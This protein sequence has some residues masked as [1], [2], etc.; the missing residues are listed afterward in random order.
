MSLKWKNELKKKQS[1]LILMT[2]ITVLFSVVVLLIDRA[3]IGPCDTS[4]GLS[5]LN[6]WVRDLIG[7][8][9]LWYVISKLS[10]YLCLILCAGFG[11]IGLAQLIHHKSLKKMDQ[12]I[13]AL[14]L[15]YVCTI[16]LYVFFEKVPLNFRPLLMEG[17][18]MPEA[19]FPSSHTMLAI[20][21]Y[22]SAPTVL[23][24]YLKD[25]PVFPLVCLA[26]YGL[27]AITVIART[28]SGVH[29][30]TDILAGLLISGTLLSA[31]FV[32]TTLIKGK[33]HH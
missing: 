20:V 11:I 31:F 14:G 25:S 15:L 22:C 1:A 4:V 12:N 26:C 19:S 32:C 13:I 29:W 10:G 2:G 23:R 27:S 7:F 17:E 9:N 6:G 30:I 3:P 33:K 5:H 16:V 8:S 21:V 28:L 18:L 24:T